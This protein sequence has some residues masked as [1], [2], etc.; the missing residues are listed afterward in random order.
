MNGPRYRDTLENWSAKVGSRSAKAYWVSI[1]GIWVIRPT[2][3]LLILSIALRSLV[4]SSV[5]N[6]AVSAMSI[7][8]VVL[9]ITTMS[10]RMLSLWLASKT[11]GVKIGIWNGKNTPP[12]DET[13][14]LEWCHAN[15]V[16][17]YSAA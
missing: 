4:P 14:Y 5:T 17:P 15:H 8:C 13:L 7:F 6:V 11:L 9:A 1:K 16:E 3:G 2:I 12:G 10:S